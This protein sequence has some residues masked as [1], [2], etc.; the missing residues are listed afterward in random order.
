MDLD[1][2]YDDSKPNGQFRKDVDTMLFK[3]L[4]PNFKFISLEEGIKKIYTH[5]KETEKRCY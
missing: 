5:Y 1:I 2:E 4:L 3:K